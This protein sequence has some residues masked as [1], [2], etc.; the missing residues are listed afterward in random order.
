ME[1]LFN[2]LTEHGPALGYIILF[3]GSLVE[4]ESVVLTAGF[5]AYKGYLSL[6]WII[7]I[8]FTATLI[9]DQASFYIGR[10]YGPNL[11]K[12]Y[13]RLKG[14]VDRIFELLHK[15]NTGFILSFRFVYGLRVASPIVIGASGID[16]KRFAILNFIAAL[17]WAVLS[18]CA[19]YLLGYLFADKIEIVM[20]KFIQYHNIG[21][22]IIVALIVGIIVIR[23]FK[24]RY[25]S[26]KNKI[27]D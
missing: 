8:S 16:P 2:L 23:A 22:G 3:L 20:K 18:C 13:P 21:V 25:F 9:A 14:K 4:G 5:L 15:Y 10:Y 19:G 17:I 7:M 24:K 26:K 1:Y 6:F 12:R 27:K 11:L